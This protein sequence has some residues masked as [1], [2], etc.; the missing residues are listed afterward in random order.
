MIYYLCIDFNLFGRV[1][2]GICRKGRT[3]DG[4]FA[5]TCSMIQLLLLPDFTSS[6]VWIGLLTLTFLEIV[7][8]VDN[9]IFVS[10]IT[11]KLEPKDQ[12][13]GRNWGLILAM[14]FRL[15]LLAFLSVILA[16][17]KPM[18]TVPFL[19][20]GDHGPIGLSIKD[21]ILIAGGLFLLYK[22]VS[23]IH[24][25][26]EGHN[27]D[28]K[29]S[30]KVTFSS[31]LIQIV[32]INIVFSFDSILTAIGLSDNVFIMALAVILSMV[33]MMIFNTR[34]S[35][36]INDHPTVQMLAFA[37]L[38]MIGFMLVA[39]G[40]HQHVSKGYMYFAIFF[41]LIVEILNIRLRKTSTAPVQLHGPLEEAE[42]RGMFDD[43]DARIAAKK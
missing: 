9:I 10:V 36:F 37:F 11:N 42:E 26:L 22:S 6:E 15:L 43:E 13:R 16:L 41:S 4:H 14:G 1:F 40:F 23:E 19:Q 12:N 33:V 20:S 38:I 30:K 27:P 25:K 39:E 28:N 29:E 2:L 18:F 31:I 5:F 24:H 8:G 7:L 21:L 32:L 34:I 35:N 17:D 3:S